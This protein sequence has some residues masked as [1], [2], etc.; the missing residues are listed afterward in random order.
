MRIYIAGPM[1][2][3][4]NDNHAEFDRIEELWWEAGH[5]PISPAYMTRAFARKIEG[6]FDNSPASIREAMIIDVIAIC[7]CDGIAL[8][9]GWDTSRGATMELA[10]AQSI[11]IDV[12]DAETMNQMLYPT[13][14]WALL[15]NWPKIEEPQ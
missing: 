6:G 2:G 5:T 10:L 7:G 13:T 9:Q 14:P 8:M 3:F 12:Y 11:G 15:R 4:E 1:R